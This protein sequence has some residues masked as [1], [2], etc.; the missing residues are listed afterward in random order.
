L[1]PPVDPGHTAPPLLAG[2][3]VLVVDDHEDSRYVLEH[4]LAYAGAEVVSASSAREAI[5]V[6]DNIDIVVTDYSMPGETGAWLLDRIRERARPIPVIALTG[7]ADIH[8]QE[9]TKAPFARVLRK[10]IDPWQLPM[11]I[12]AV[13][14]GS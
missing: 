2:I 6:L 1:S 4:V 11:A 12:A 3:R 9:L 13:L 5:A 7:F 14:R 10:P 8:V